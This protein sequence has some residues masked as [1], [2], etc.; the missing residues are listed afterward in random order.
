[1]GPIRKRPPAWLNA[2]L[3]APGHGVPC[4]LLGALVSL[5]CQVSAVERI[6]L[7]KSRKDARILFRE[8]TK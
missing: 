7:Q 6:V 3:G 2:A 1:M 8:R 5:G 4:P